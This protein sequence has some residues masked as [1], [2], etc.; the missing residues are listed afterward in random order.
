[1]KRIQY[2]FLCALMSICS[3]TAQEMTNQTNVQVTEQANSHT[4]SIVITNSAG[5]G[6][7]GTVRLT[8][9]TSGTIS[10]S[11]A[12]SITCNPTMMLSPNLIMLS[13]DYTG[14]SCKLEISNNYNYS[15]TIS[16][17]NGTHYQNAIAL[18]PNG[19][20][21]ISLRMK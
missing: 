15:T 7:S 10:T 4:V 14:S 6:K 18:N 2:F 8:S 16:A 1:M 5:S 21:T 11:G 17:S 20:T 19:Y 12:S 13:F 9:P 3:L